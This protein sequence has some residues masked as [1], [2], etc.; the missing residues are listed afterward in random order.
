M[1]IDVAF[2]F[3][4]ALILLNLTVLYKAGLYICATIEA[5]AFSGI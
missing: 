3:M 2:R 5:K 1:L 4:T